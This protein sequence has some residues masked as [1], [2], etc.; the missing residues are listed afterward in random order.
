MGGEEM[1]PISGT[2][3]TVFSVL[4]QKSVITGTECPRVLPGCRRVRG[5]SSQ[6]HPYLRQSETLPK[7]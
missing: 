6:W 3:I 1:L 2:I 4:L 5:K 7:V